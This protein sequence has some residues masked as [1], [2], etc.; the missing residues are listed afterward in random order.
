VNEQFLSLSGSLISAGSLKTTLVNSHV[1]LYQSSFTPN[2]GSVLADFVSAEADF[3]GYPAGGIV[4]A[5]MNDPI[6]DPAGGYSIGS[7]VVQFETDPAEATPNLIGGWFLV[8]AGTLLY[9]YGSYGTPVPMQLP[10]QG[11]PI[12]FRWGFPTA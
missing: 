1:R 5:A 6:L 11:L 10:G 12:N 8:T 2:P 3:D 7:P 4:V 9:G